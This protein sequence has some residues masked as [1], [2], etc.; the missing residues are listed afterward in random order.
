MGAN[1]TGPTGTLHPDH[2]LHPPPAGEGFRGPLRCQGLLVVS[3]LGCRWAPVLPTR[4]THPV[5]PTLVPPWDRTPPA[6]MLV[7]GTN[8]VYR[9]LGSCTYGR[10]WDGLGEPRGV[11]YRPVS[12]SRDWFI[13][14]LRFT[15][16]FDWII[17]CF[18]PVLL[19]YG[20]VLLSYGTRFTELWTRFTELTS[21]LTS[22]LTS[23]LTSHM[24]HY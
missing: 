6:D 2:P 19:S 4:I 1:W 16:P 8:T 14:Y 23:V 9:S 24:P 7:P 12:G 11:E 17:D 18:R 20:P 13:Q 21:E 10:F 15:R 5:Y 3:D 22:V